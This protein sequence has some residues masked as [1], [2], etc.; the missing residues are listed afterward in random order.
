M[1][2]VTPASSQGLE[3]PPTAAGVIQR[4]RGIVQGLELDCECR[5]KLDSALLRFEALE[6]RRQLR[7]LILDARH[8]TE[9]IAALL[10]L[11]REL[12]E[13]PMD[14]PDLSVFEEVALLFE[15]IEEAAARGAADMRAAREVRR[16]DET[17]PE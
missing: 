16:P 9:R 13:L 11:A 7:R 6:D 3:A 8:Q 10:D 14:E 17:A 1:I 2:E 5:S 4:V 12:D 15:G